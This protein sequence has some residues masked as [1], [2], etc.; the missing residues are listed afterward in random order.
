M[1][2]PMPEPI[3]PLLSELGRR[4]RSARTAA[5]RTLSDVASE[6]GISRRYLTEAEG[7]R[8][9]PSLSVLVALAR[10]LGT[11]PAQLVD[12]RLAAPRAERIALVGLR[13]AGQSTVGR[14]LARAREVPFVELDRRVEEHAGRTLSEIFDPSGPEV[15]HRYE[16]EALERILAEGERLVIAT[17]GSIVDSPR[18][19][20]RLRETCTTVWLKT[21]P[22]EYMR[23]V[24]G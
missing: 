19:F 5:G 22:E 8:A 13:G 7:G 24:V 17:G 11:T 20:A 18:N 1:I 2:L 23:R 21:T 15:F 12:I 10:A 3:Q 9:N 6:A 4:L 16:G 14:L